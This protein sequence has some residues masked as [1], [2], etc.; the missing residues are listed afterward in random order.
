MELPDNFIGQWET[1]VADVHKTDVPLECV[2]KIIFK[3]RNRRQK[4]INVH[5]LIKQG[6]GFQEIE[7]LLS[8]MIAELEPELLDIEFA[9]DIS[10][11]ARMVQPE[12]DKLLG[13]I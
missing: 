6:I 7:S 5:S 2:K 4:T 9:L 10:S 8:R 11:V 13:K 1:I 3:L 12:T